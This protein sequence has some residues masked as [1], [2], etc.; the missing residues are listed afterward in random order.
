MINHSQKRFQSG[1]AVV[2]AMGVVALAAMAAAAL[3]VSQNTWARHNELAAQR[4]QALLVVKAG[5]DWG[6][7]VLKDDRRTSSVD[8][9][10]EPWALRLPPLPVDN[11][12][13]N[14]YLED[15]NGRFNL[16]NLVRNGQVDTVQLEHFQRLLSILELPH[17]L[18]YALADWLDADGESY[19][20]GGA[21]D[22][23]YRV[24]DTPYLAANRPMT[25][26][27]ELAL[28][29]GFEESMRTRLLPYVTALPRFTPVN[30]NTA[31]PEVLAAIVE[32]LSLAEA[33]IVVTR[34][35]R[36]YARNPADFR[37]MLPKDTKFA[38]NDITVNSEYFVARIHVVIGGAEAHGAA[39]LARQGSDWPTVIWRKSL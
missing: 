15:Q 14:G 8:H 6:R 24:L 1:V 29:S 32:G 34:R 31:A 19:S 33:S 38:E 17:T 16:N 11:G 39:L 2:L 21:E 12:K 9:L 37:L 18:A 22:S 28:V 4:T 26:V 25:D 5:I 7:A 36:A 30:V 20:K 10:G 23:Y 13:L 27:S 3:L 35:E